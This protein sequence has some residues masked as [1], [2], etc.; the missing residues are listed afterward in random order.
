MKILL[1]FVAIAFVFAPWRASISTLAGGPALQDADIISIT[2]EE[3]VEAKAAHAELVEAMRKWDAVNTLL[4]RKYI[5]VPCQSTGSGGRIGPTTCNREGFDN[6]FQFTKDYKMLI[7]D[8]T[9]GATSLFN[10]WKIRV[11]R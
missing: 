1:S 10:C 8:V 11:T 2:S 3:S 7:P 9:P 5:T 6:G 4:M